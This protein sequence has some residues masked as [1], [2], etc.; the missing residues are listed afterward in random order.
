MT[1]ALVI[2][3]M[4]S[5]RAELRLYLHEFIYLFANSCRAVFRILDKKKN[6]KKNIVPGKEVF[7]VVA[8]KAFLAADFDNN[9]FLTLDEIE[10]WCLNNIEFQK[11]L[12]RFGKS[13]FIKLKLFRESK[14]DS[15]RVQSF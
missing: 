10:M 7:R 13:H 5:L 12:H 9:G 14:S 1:L 3:R 15:L 4:F 2:T 11:F 6:N 8:K